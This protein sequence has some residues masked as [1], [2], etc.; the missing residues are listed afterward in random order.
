MSLRRLRRGELVV[1]AGVICL[2]VSLFEPWYEGPISG[3]LDAWD[4]F[5]AA[6]ALLLA[7]LCAGLAVVVSAIGERDAALPV[8]AAV[9][10]V[11]LGLIGVIA[12]VVRVLER[13]DHSS[14]LCI[15]AWLA[16][17]GAVAILAGSWLVLDDER[18]GS[19]RA[20][21]PSP[22]SRP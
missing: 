2:A 6:A 16:L 9:W 3:Q 20:A 17:I 21:A 18:P 7:C 8:A 13:P 14:S 11:L 4:T 5:G 15:G 10:S 1:L 12:A 19:Y 22:R